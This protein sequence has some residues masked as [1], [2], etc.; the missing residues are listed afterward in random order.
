LT[1]NIYDSKV[2]SGLEAAEAL[3]R[4]IRKLE[5]RKVKGLTEKQ[6]H[7]LVKTAKILRTEIIRTKDN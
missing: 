3:D 5:K 6:V 2:L 4:Y 1:V 7:A